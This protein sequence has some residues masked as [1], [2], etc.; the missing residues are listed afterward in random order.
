MVAVELFFERTPDGYIKVR[1]HSCGR[2][3]IF[4]SSEL[5]APAATSAVT[6]RK[7]CPQCG[8]DAPIVIPAP[9]SWG[10]TVPTSAARSQ[11]HAITPRPWRSPPWLR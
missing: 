7:A 4:K 11:W 9:P 2:S 1:C 5:F 6:L 8:S 3:R 10:W